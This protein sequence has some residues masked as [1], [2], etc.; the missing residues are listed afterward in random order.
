MLEN[1]EF[2]LQEAIDE[3]L[4]TLD[5]YMEGL[6]LDDDNTNPRRPAQVIEDLA[7]SLR[8]S[9]RISSEAQNNLY[10]DPE[11]A[12]AEARQQ[13][14]D[15]LFLQ[16]VKR[17]VGAITRRIED[18]LDID[19]N[20][21]AQLDWDSMADALLDAV[22]LE[23]TQRWERYI[24]ETEDGLIVRDID[25]ALP[26]LPLPWDNPENINQ[27]LIA[28]LLAIPQGTR[29]AFDRKTHRKLTLRTRRL[30]FIYGAAQFLENRE[31]EEIT[32]DVLNHLEEAQQATWRTWGASEWKRLSGSTID[33]LQTGTRE[34]LAEI[35]GAPLEP[36]T[37][38]QQLAS[39]HKDLIS[40]EL[41]RQALTAVY[42]Q[43][44]LSIISELWVE[45]LTQMEALRVSV[46][47]EAYAQRDP[48]VQ[49][50]SK[51]FELFQQ[52]LH[53]MRQGVVNRMFTYRPRDL[54]SVQA[55]ISQAP[56]P[57]KQIPESK[58]TVPQNDGADSTSL[59]KE[60]GEQGQEKTG[61]KKRRRRR[62]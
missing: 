54:N 26:R 33:D 49:Y 60:K 45:Y 32:D 15:T 8:I 12:R 42:R 2:R 13:I 21:L 43:L 28:M 52:L 51:A 40:A 18:A 9:L 37:D 29:T 59:P 23:F 34:K 58:D 4:E 61:K 1:T 57:Q 47:L 14:E 19:I 44:M 39:Q 48:L 17:L 7:S 22:E 55:T 6:Y 41:G 35:T 30:V 20:Q 25:K 56:I 46:G 62:R 5:T 50:K 11:L 3:R 38:I 31:P 53:D 24:G 16:T 27:N 10:T 36:G